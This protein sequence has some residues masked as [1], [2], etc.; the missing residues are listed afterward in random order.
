MPVRLLTTV[1]ILAVTVLIG[2]STRAAW[3]VRAT[4][5]AVDCATQ[6]CQYLPLVVQ[7]TTAQPTTTTTT[8]TTAQPTSTTRPTTTAQPTTTAR[9][10]TTT[11]PTQLPPSFNNC[12]AD[13]NRENAPDY[14]VRITDIDKQAETVTLENR[15]GATID[16]TGWRMCSI[17]G[18]QQHPI[19][20][21]LAPGQERTFTNNGGSIWSNTSEDDG[22]LYDPQGHL[23]SYRNG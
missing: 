12:Q 4:P 22:A 16:L 21:T 6:D 5:A 11:T 17:T 7:A 13:P 9:P 18:N 3:A 1:A 2:W 23:V 14:P 8:T 20:G 15:S 19:G 10:T